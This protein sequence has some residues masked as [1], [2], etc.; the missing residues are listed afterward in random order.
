MTEIHE[1]VATMLDIVWQGIPNSYKSKYRQTIW[2]QFEDNIRDAAGT[3]NNLGR[4]INSLC[5]GLNATP[6]KNADDRKALLEILNDGNDKAIMKLM[7]NET[8]RLVLMV[9][10]RNQERQEEWKA[11]QKERTGEAIDMQQQ[12]EEVTE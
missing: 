12:F 10:V 5:L 11:T 4:F 8:L 3:N 7:R 2:Q 9:R 6:G 1:Q